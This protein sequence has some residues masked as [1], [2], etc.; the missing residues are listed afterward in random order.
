MWES[1]LSFFFLLFTFLTLAFYQ[2]VI[3]KSRTSAPLR[4]LFFY[5]IF[6]FMVIEF[7]PWFIITLSLYLSDLLSI[8]YQINSY[9]IM[10]TRL[11][12]ISGSIKLCIDNVGL[13]SEFCIWRWKKK[14]F[15][16]LVTIYE[17]RWNCLESNTM[18]SLIS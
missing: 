16:L 1:I 12:Y 11:H 8:I 2:K 18:Y 15:D 3:L 5:F 9:Y 10:I 7:V 6:W 13:Q 14:M 17:Q 4:I